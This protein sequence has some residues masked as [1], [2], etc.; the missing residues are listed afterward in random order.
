MKTLTSALLLGTLMV[1]GPAIAAQNSAQPSDQTTA[2]PRSN[3]S[4]QTLTQLPT[5]GLQ[6]S[7]FYKQNVYDPKD[8]KIGDVK[9][10]ILEKDGRV[11]AAIIGV[12]G[13][14]ERAK[15]T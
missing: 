9:D 8:N 1:S 5:S 10:L 7:D 13:F 6:V 3:P 11:N 2:V 14:L 4:S 15:R 12:G